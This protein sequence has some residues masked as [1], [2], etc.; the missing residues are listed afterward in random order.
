[1]KQPVSFVEIENIQLALKIYCK[2]EDYFN[3][4]LQILASDNY[5]VRKSD[6]I[7]AAKEIKSLGEIIQY[8]SNEPDSKISS[9]IPEEYF[10]IPIEVFCKYKVIDGYKHL[11]EMLD[12]QCMREHYSPTIL[13]TNNSQDELHC[14]H[15]VMNDLIAWTMK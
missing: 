8:L 6:I 13:T 12:L 4:S 11:E 1:M 2:E 10:N 5:T 7:Y 15:K 3:V 9:D 14:R